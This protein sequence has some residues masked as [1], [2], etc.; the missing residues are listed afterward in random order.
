MRTETERI[1]AVSKVAQDIA[2]ALRRTTDMRLIAMWTG[3]ESPH[4]RV[5]DTEAQEYRV[6]IEAVDGE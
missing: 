3:S 5:A 1:K 6:S 2:T 4:L